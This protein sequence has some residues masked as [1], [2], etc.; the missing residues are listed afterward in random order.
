[1]WVEVQLLWRQ[2][3]VLRWFWSD[4]RVGGA[5]SSCSRSTYRSSVFH[6]LNSQVA[7]T[8]FARGFGLALSFSFLTDLTV[9][10][11]SLSTS[12]ASASS[13]IDWSPTSVTETS[14]TPSLVSVADAVH[15]NRWVLPRILICI[16]RACALVGGTNGTP[17]TAPSSA[18]S[19]VN[20]PGSGV[21]PK[22]ILLL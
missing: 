2:G 9:T 10:P 22:R 20:V 12:I 14:G 3:F 17:S 8:D 4:R 11:T 13:S 5:G 18:T 1:M 15:F 7:G 21:G 19:E 16:L 6:T